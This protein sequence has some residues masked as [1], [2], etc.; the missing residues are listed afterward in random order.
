MS[1]RS[2][3]MA[4]E[5]EL[6]PAEERGSNQS[7]HSEVK[8]LVSVHG[9]EALVTPCCSGIAAALTAW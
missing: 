6:S 4:D 9:S 8:F 5:G 3:A 1:R 2:E 7:V